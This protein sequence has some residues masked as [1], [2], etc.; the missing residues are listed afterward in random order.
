MY[1]R[2]QGGD[3]LASYGSSIALGTSGSNEENILIDGS[4]VDIRSG[5]TSLAD[6]GS[7]VRIGKSGQARTEITDTAIS[8]YDGQGT[9]RKRVAINNAGV[10]AVGGRIRCRCCGRF[11]R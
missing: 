7:T 8:M 11:N 9:P 3:T 1:L 5:T 10:I 6:F 2:N 4:S